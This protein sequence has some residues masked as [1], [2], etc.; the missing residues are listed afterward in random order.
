MRRGA[1]T[2]SITQLL[3]VMF[4]IAVC[5]SLV[6]WIITEHSPEE[7]RNIGWTILGFEGGGIAYIAAVY[8]LGPG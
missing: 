3:F 8:F 2:M 1:N 6:G 5:C 4:L 7:R